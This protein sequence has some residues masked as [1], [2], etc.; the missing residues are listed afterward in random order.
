MR[1]EITYVPHNC[2]V[3]D[4]ADHVLVFDGPAARCMSHDAGQ[5]LAGRVRGRNVTVFCSH[6][7][8][9]HFHQNL[10]GLLGVSADARYVLSDDIP[11]MYPEAK[12]Q[13]A[14]IV[15]PDQRYALHGMEIETLLSND[16]GVAFVIRCSGLVI[17]YGGDLAAWVWDNAPVADQAFARDFFSRSLA[18]LPRPIDIAFSNVDKRLSNLAGGVEFVQSVRPR[19]FVPMHTFGRTRWTRDFA[20]AFDA[21][22]TEIFVY[23]RPGDA[24]AFE[25]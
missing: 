4:L 12:P 2:F 23:S 17:Y 8:E 24:A 1:A 15:E 11:D 16:L 19:V 25:L 7:H 22:E 3:L 18:R 10:P 20:A 9:D 21:A 6:S 14:L 13:G 5:A